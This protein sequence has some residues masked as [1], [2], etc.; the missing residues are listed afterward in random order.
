MVT[1]WVAHITVRTGVRCA[2]DLTALVA[3]EGTG[4]M[5]PFYGRGLRDP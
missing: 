4:V 5:R 2:V 3:R 1:V